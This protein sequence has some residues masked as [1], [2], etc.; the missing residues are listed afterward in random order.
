MTIIHQQDAPVFELPGITFTGLTSPSRGSRENSLW[1]FVLQPGV[2]GTPHRI[3]R[4]ETFLAL[5]G[6]AVLEIDGAP[7][8]FPAGSAFAVP[9][10]SVVS[11]SNP[12]PEAFHAVAVFPV[13]GQVAMGEAPAFTPPWAA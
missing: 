7:H 5:D 2:S 1:R 11:M 13:G 8:D 12:G 4:E 6:R 9:A 3:T 10:G